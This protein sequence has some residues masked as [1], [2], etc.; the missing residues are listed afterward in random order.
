[1]V[2]E[3]CKGACCDGT[4]CTSVV[5]ADCTGVWKGRGTVCSPNPCGGGECPVGG[6]CVCPNGYSTPSFDT[7]W[8]GG[9]APSLTVNCYATHQYDAFQNG[10]FA[11]SGSGSCSWSVTVTADL[12]CATLGAGNFPCGSDCSLS[13]VTITVDDSGCDCPGELPS[14]SNFEYFS[15]F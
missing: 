5:K 8:P 3:C 2:C 6:L 13:N 12:T 14:T 15:C 10:S 9:L 4:T 7:T 1:M 11:C